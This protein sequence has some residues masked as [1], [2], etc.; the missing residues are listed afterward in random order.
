MRP[1]GPTLQCYI[2]SLMSSKPVVDL[3]HSFVMKCVNL[4]ARMHVDIACGKTVVGIIH[5]P[6]QDNI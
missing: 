3:T 4:M 2:M 5:S 6:S 1:K